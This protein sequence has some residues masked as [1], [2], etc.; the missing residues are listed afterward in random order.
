MKQKHAIVT[1][2]LWV[3]LPVTG[4]NHYLLIFS[5]LRSGTEGKTAILSFATQH[6]MSQ[7]CGGNSETECVNRS[8]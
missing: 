2:W 7:K 1:Q 4:M 3:R 6:V 5:F 8:K